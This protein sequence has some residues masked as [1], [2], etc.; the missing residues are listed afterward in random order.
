MVQYYTSSIFLTNFIIWSRLLNSFAT[1]S[2]FLYKWIFLYKSKKLKTSLG[3]CFLYTVIVFL[4]MALW[5]ENKILD[6]KNNYTN[7][8]YNYGEFMND[9]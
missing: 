1:F 3:T 5:N 7:Y 9:Q 6:P 4:Q 2:L 8:R